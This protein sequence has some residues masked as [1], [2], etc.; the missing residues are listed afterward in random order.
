V[1]EVDAQEVQQTGDKKKKPKVP[2]KQVKVIAPDLDFDESRREEERSKALKSKFHDNEVM[3]G[4]L[5]ATGDA[6]LIHKCGSGEP[7]TPD[8]ELMRTRDSI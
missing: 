1:K 7:A 4:L 2:K 6:F 3:R 5:K 8:L